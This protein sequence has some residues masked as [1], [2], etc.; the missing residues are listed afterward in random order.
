MTNLLKLLIYVYV[1]IYNFRVLN[2][3]NASKLMLD[4]QCVIKFSLMNKTTNK[5]DVVKTER[6]CNGTDDVIVGESLWV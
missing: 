3:Y 6:L 1:R 5:N 4:I 2:V